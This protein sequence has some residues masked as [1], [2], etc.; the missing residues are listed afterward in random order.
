MSNTEGEHEFEIRCETLHI[1]V[2]EDVYGHTKMK[3]PSFTHPQVIL[4]V[5]LQKIK[6]DILMNTDNQTVSFPIDFWC[7]DKNTMKVNRNPKCLFTN[8][9]QNIILC[10][11]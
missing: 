4:N 1:F 2:Y 7:M 9:L 3:I 8:I 5:L 6:Y 10:F 11:E